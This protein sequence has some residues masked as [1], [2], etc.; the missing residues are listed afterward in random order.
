MYTYRIA[1]VAALGGLL[2]GF[3]TAIINGAIIFLKRQFHWTEVQTEIAASS[4]LFGCVLGASIAGALSD[5]FGRRRILSAA[6]ALFALS[7]LVTAL[8]N[9]LVQ[10]CA[11]RIVAGVAIGVASMLSPLYIAEISPASIRG[12]LVGLNQFAIVM[13]ILV[14]YLVGWLLAGIGDQNWRWMFASAFAPSLLFLFALFFVPESP[15]WLAKENRD[16]EGLD[17][18]RKIGEGARA[19]ARLAEI[20]AAIA[21]ES[22]SLAQVL[23]SDMRRPLLIGV[24]LAV[25]QQVTGI[26]TIMYYGS[27][28]FTEQAGEKAASAALGANVVIGVVCLLSTIVSLSVIDRLGRKSLLMI[29]AAGMGVSLAVLGILFRA[30]ASAKGPIL[31]MILCYVACFNV[32]MGP[33]VWV[34][35]SEL[36]PTRIRGRAMSVA[37]IAL[38]IACL[39]ITVT[40]LSLVKALT[41]SGAFWT[42]AAVCVLTFL[43][44]WRFTVETKGKTLEEIE[45]GWCE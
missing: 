43:F 5:R 17:V 2:F 25:L 26:N 24:T 6:A 33:T 22:G 28:I 3:D 15:R 23:K 10:F 39:A 36:F 16:I 21:Q 30:D 42:Y 8:P 44:V 41:I 37:T 1:S 7:S 18:L 45:Q 14:S 19:A 4:L 11:A 31:G 38:W 29:A 35:L 12:F 32:G 20:K 9:T 34:L 40:F 13:G 27:I